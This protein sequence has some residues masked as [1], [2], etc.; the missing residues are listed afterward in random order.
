MNPE[1]ETEATLL[2]ELFTKASYSILTFLYQQILMSVFSLFL[3][4]TLGATIYGFI[5]VV[6][7]A[8]QTVSSSI[9]G[10]VVGNLRTIP[11]VGNN[12]KKH[13]ISISLYITIFIWLIISILAILLVDN[14]VEITVLKPRHE[15]LVV[16]SLLIFLF[17]M[18]L[19]N[20]SSIYRSDKNIKI[21][22]FFTKILKP[23]SYLLGAIVAVLFY[24][25]ADSIR[26][27][28]SISALLGLSAICAMYLVNRKANITINVSYKSPEVQN[29]L[30]Y[31]YDSSIIAFLGLMH[32]KIVFV[33]MAVAVSPVAAGLF[34]LCLILAKTG[35]WPLQSINKIFGPIATRLYSKDRMDILDSLYKSS[36]KV[37]TFF[38]CIPFI[39][40]ANFH[41][42]MLTLF[43]PQYAENS[44]ILPIAYLAQIFATLAGSVGLLLLMTD[45]ERPT[46]YIGISNVLLMIPISVILTVKFGVLGLSIS[47][48][49]TI[50]YNN[51]AE[52][53]ALYYLEQISPITPCHIYLILLVSIFSTIPMT[54][55]FIGMETRMKLSI[56]V[57]L[58]TA[59]SLISY[60]YLLN[61]DERQSL[62]KILNQF[63]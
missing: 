26:V 21:G 47:F 56:S 15:N 45:N 62:G 23:S 40:V 17:S 2:S 6:V 10:V 28:G 16:V 25:S 54:I 38:C 13:I 29:F 43:S 37:A 27:V 39:L 63:S 60:R 52:L 18:L 4:N 55:E 1:D 34:S 24:S 58:S 50:I 22:M 14:I 30:S 51:L 8:E 33:I 35:R 42:P 3:T 36:S 20:A 7:R 46:L 5:S 61:K 12:G 9:G 59:Y 32:R 31:T 57:L 49:F 48:L 53:L 41:Q 11:R 19:A 44:I